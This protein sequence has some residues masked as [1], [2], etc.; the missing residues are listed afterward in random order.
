MIRSVLKNGLKVIRCL[1][2][3]SSTER[4]RVLAGLAC[5]LSLLLSVPALSGGSLPDGVRITHPR[6]GFLMETAPIEIRDSIPRDEAGIVN[7]ARVPDETGFAVLIRSAHGI[8]TH[9][10]DAVRFTIDDGLLPPYVRDLRSDTVRTVKLDQDPDEQV[11]VLWAVYDRFLETYIP[12]TYPLNAVIY[13]KVEVRD[14]QNNILQ[15]PAF[16]FKI[17]NLARKAA[18]RQNLP[19]TDEFYMIDPDSGDPYDA[20]IEIID[21]ELSGAKVVYSSRE[22]LTPAFGPLDGIEEINL[23]GILAAGQPVNLIPHTVFDVPVKLFI[24]VA[25][26]VDITTAGLA[27]HDGTQWLAAADADGNVLS[28]GEGWMVPGSRVNHAETRP[29]LIEVQVYHFSGAQAVV[30]GMTEEED[31]PPDHGSGTVV[32]ASC[33]MNS[34]AGGTNF[35][36]F[37]A[38]IGMVV[39]GLLV[40]FV[41][42]RRE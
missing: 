8:D 26:G 5:I 4:R 27:Y 31:K 17:E 38:L 12:M 34:V 25:D 19:E 22:P 32:Y 7:F 18:S 23:D 40:Y 37:V 36:G 2:R 24:P 33:F 13:I 20:G 6:N 11:T 41:R 39:A 14:I 21:G 1:P 35:G 28:D 29:A 3:R 42:G 30:G 10:P 9:A 15:P 16:E